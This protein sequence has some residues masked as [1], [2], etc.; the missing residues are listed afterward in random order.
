MKKKKKKKKK[1]MVVLSLVCFFCP[2][3]FAVS[4]VIDYMLTF[5]FWY[6]IVICKISF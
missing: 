4:F 3:L 2:P 5:S 6:L 1:K